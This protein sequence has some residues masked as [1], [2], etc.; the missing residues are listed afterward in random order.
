[1]RHLGLDRLDPARGQRR[2][3]LPSGPT[4]AAR[5]PRHGLLWP[6]NAH[7]H[8]P[9]LEQRRRRHAADRHRRRR[10]VGL[11]ARR[12]VRRRRRLLRLAP[13]AAAP[14]GAGAPRADRVPV[15]ARRRAARRR[16]RAAARR[17][18]GRAVDRPRRGWRCSRG[19]RY[20]AVGTA[21]LDLL[22]ADAGAAI[23]HPLLDLRPVG[24]GRRGRSARGVH[25]RATP[26]SAPSPGSCCPAELVARRTKAS[27]DAR[28]LQRA[29]A[30]AR[31]RVG[32]ARRP[33]DA[34]RR[35]RA[36]RALARSDD[37]RSALADAAAG[38]W[39]AS[40]GDRVQQPRRS[41]RAV[42]PSR[43][44]ASAAGAAAR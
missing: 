42:S 35:R 40:A 7:F 25:A 14:R 33:G 18:R 4:P 36:A 44:G 24:R 2:A 8:L 23:A 1:M 22:A 20:T 34:R 32:R 41:R 3:R 16:R 37:A 28:L 26:R 11:V 10:A 17:G 21:A 12:P 39:L 6:F 31:A 9:M 43:A 19:M 15:A 27:F 29:R 13:F 38:A 5:W 30:R